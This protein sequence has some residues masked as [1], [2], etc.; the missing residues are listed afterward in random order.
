MDLVELTDPHKIRAIYGDGVTAP[1]IL[2]VE[3]CDVDILDDNIL[4]AIGHTK[5]LST[6]DTFVPYT[7]DRFVGANVNTRHACGIIDNADRLYAFAYRM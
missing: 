3:V 2:G 6:N 7:D 4:R 1:D 5:P